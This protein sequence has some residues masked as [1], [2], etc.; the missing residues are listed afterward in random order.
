MIV[1]F[2]VVIH[3]AGS[4]T[5][6]A[7]L[8][9]WA[10]PLEF[11]FAVGL[12]ALT[13]F[14]INQLNSVFH[15]HPRVMTDDELRRTLRY[16]LDKQSYGFGP[17]KWD[18]TVFAFA[19]TDMTGRPIFIGRFDGQQSIKI[20]ANP[21]VAED[22]TRALIDGMM[23]LPGAGMISGLQLELAQF[24]IWYNGATLP[25]ESLTISDEL[26]INSLTE[27]TFME[28]V[29]LIR[30]GHILV[31]AI[32]ARAFAVGDSF[33]PLAVESTPSAATP[34]PTAEP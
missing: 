21:V 7:V 20:A 6:W 9:S 28:R 11:L 31:V 3:V 15:R 1:N 25:L 14:T 4:G 29:N 33:M 10:G 5:A 12:V 22:G 30:R 17:A 18:G 8:E 27:A 32:M 24:W 13:F 16:W 2:V 34:Q 23:P 26:P 19:A